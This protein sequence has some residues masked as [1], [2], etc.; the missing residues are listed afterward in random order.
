MNR[1]LFLFVGKSASGKTTVA[2]MLEEKYFFNQVQ[3]YT[4]RPPRYDGE[5]GHIF[6]TEEEFNNLED[7]VSY[8][9]YNNNQYG[10]TASLLDKNDIF[11]VDVPGVE[12]L[13]QKYK[14]ERPICIIYF[15]TTVATRI[16]RMIDRGDSDVAIISRLLQDEENDWF[17]ELDKLV[18]H[19]GHIMRRN[20]NLHFVNA[21][22]NQENVLEMVLYYIN[23]YMED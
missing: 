20:V 5:A 21:N 23:Q 14:T 19:Y 22:G 1:P 13:L 3:S 10:T 4:T 8:T 6:L 12:S 16:N 7:I 9:L 2:N 15:D 18:W 11:V 17:K